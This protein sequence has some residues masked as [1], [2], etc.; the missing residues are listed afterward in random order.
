[1]FT[2]ASTSFSSTVVAVIGT[3][4]F[5]GACLFGATAPAAAATATQAQ[6]VSYTDLNVASTSGRK[7]LDSR[8]LHAARNVCETG[9]NDVR[10]LNAE[11]RCVDAAV[12]DARSKVYSVSASN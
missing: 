12:A 11:A 4:L 6:S 7:I 1:M 3:A 10:A 8:I 5:A 9:S 2:T